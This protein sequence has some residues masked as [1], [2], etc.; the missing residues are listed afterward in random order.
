MTSKAKEIECLEDHL[1]YELMMLRYTRSR[2]GEPQSAL[3]WNATLESFA[4]HAR[5]LFEF[6]TNDGESRN[7]KA[8]DFSHGYVAKGKEKMRGKRDKLNE[9]LFHLAKTRSSD[10]HKKVS[11]EVAIVLFDWIE[12]RFEGFLAS[13]SPDWATIGTLTVRN[14]R[15]WC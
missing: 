9:G 13:L 4:M 1:P 10:H 15:R 2:L 6:L 8:E 3:I 11:T 14:Q 7:F 12:D 5:L